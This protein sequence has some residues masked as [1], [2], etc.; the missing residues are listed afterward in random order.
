MSRV[1][2]PRYLSATSASTSPRAHSLEQVPPFDQTIGLD[3]R[4]RR[5]VSPRL[6]HVFVSYT[7]PRSSRFKLTAIVSR[8]PRS[9]ATK[10]ASRRA[11]QSER[12]CYPAE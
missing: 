9:G 7:D 8:R 10:T 3:S 11:K 6:K 1:V 5:C 4:A 2:S 12:D